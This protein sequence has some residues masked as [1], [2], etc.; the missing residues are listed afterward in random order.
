[1]NLVRQ[2]AVDNGAF[3]AV[4]CDHW[5]LGGAG[6]VE[7][8]DAVIEACEKESTFNYLYPLGISIQEK[9]K[10]I[11]TEMYGAGQI[12]YTDDV[13]EKIKVFTEMVS[14]G[15]MPFLKTSINVRS[16]SIS[17]IYVLTY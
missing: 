4:V 17:F 5:A 9:V 10:L 16:N 7:L 13:M 14:T 11:A 1:M 15:A 8:A 3:K 6:A 12:E 2:F